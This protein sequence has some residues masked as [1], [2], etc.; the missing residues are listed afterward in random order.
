MVA[1][2]FFRLINCKKAHIFKTY[3][4]PDETNIVKPRDDLISF[5][6]K[7]IK[8]LS[9]KTLSAIFSNRTPVAVRV[10]MNI[11]LLSLGK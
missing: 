11:H 8:D 10:S 6:P 1:I 4:A 2:S 5:M 9:G 7:D 3:A